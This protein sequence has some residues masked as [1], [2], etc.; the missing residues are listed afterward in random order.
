MKYYTK[1]RK[2]EEEIEELEHYFV[3]DYLEP[4]LHNLPP[5]IVY[6][7]F[8]YF[9]ETKERVFFPPFL[10]KLDLPFYYIYPLDNLPDSVESMYVTL[11]NQPIIFPINLFSLHVR[12]ED[13]SRL[14][15]KY[16]PKSLKIL[17][18]N[19]VTTKE[20]WTKLPNVKDLYIEGKTD[21]TK[22][23][24]SVK[25]LTLETKISMLKS[26]P[27]LKA[28]YLTTD[29]CNLLPIFPANIKRVSIKCDNMEEVMKQLK[30]LP[31]RVVKP[32]F[33]YDM[34]DE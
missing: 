22:V 14:P 33:S 30:Y 12:L 3:N 25:K 2:I 17:K 1:L 16:L 24:N 11:R 23:P 4:D 34:E 6:L 8:N 13:N 15:I 9:Y 31:K 32:Y 7:E 29:N 10:R 18:V 28:F 26:P 21:V 5:T 27:H 20:D 19:N